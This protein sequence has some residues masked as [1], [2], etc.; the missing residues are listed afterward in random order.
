MKCKDAKKHISA[1]MDGEPVPAGLFP[2]VK[3]C[4][5][6]AREFEAA[7]KI[8]AAFAVKEDIKVKRGF[9]E[10]V[11]AKIGEPG[12]SIA[13]RIFLRPANYMKAAAVAAAFLILFLTA[14]N[15]SVTEGNE[16]AS[17]EERKLKANKAAAE[18]KKVENKET[19]AQTPGVLT[20]D[21][22]GKSNEVAVN[23][24]N[25][26]SIFREVIKDS[27]SSEK[28]RETPLPT[29]EENIKVYNNVV[30]PLQN[31]G[32]V[33]R[34]K[35]EEAAEINIVVYSK[36]G[37]PV[38]KL[39]SGEKTRGVYEAEWKGEDESGKA[40]ADGIYIVYVKTGL[41]EKKIKAM[42]VK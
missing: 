28:E 20:K 14:R 29:M 8:K 31:K 11:W 36:M 26:R 19:A 9:N 1:Y 35:V 25:P 12:P 39:F 16:T 18:I 40:V 4:K 32:I 41:V 37:E 24:E 27:G 33:I 6:C 42:V 17:Q 15:F 22:E 5:K 2:H 13:S 38:K 10:G 3:S 34:Y 7:K 21:D 23:N 30:K